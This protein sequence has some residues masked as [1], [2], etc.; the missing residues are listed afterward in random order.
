MIKSRKVWQAGMW[1]A[2]GDEYMD[3]GFEWILTHCGPVASYESL[4]I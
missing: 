3:I 2:C 4:G 1:N